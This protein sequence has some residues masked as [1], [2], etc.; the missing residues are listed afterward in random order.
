MIKEALEFM[1]SKQAKFETM[2]DTY[3]KQHVGYDGKH[4]RIVE[5]TISGKFELTTLQGI[6]DYIAEEIDAQ[7]HDSNLTIH[8]ESP[9]MISIHTDLN[10]D[11]NRT[12]V[13]ESKAILS[14]F[15]WDHYYDSDSFMVHLLS[16]FVP[17]DDLQNLVKLIGT[18]SIEEGVTTE[19]DGVTQRITAKKGVRLMGKELLPPR[20][21]LSPIRTFIEVEQPISEFVLRVQEAGGTIECALFQADGGYWRIDAM[22]SIMNYLKDNLSQLEIYDK[23]KI[24]M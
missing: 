21:K 18:M 11:L 5:D 7:A 8:I 6:V 17:T 19:D 1:L 4:T 3:G 16:N 12:E 9:S 20:V 14:N 22:Q 10:S 13:V 15:R 24:L 2:T 23:I